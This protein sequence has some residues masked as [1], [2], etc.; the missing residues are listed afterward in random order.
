MIV[1]LTGSMASG[2]TTV[3]KLL[4]ARGFRCVDADEA[5][6]WIIRVPEVRDKL[7]AA[8][9]SDIL[10]VSGSIDRTALAKKAFASKE[11]T[12]LLNSVTHP[13]IIA[14]MLS[15][16]KRLI[17]EAPERPVLMDVPLL[18]ES[19]MDQYCDR[20]VTVAAD[21]EVRYLRIMLRDGIT[22]EEAAKR[23]S[24]Q[25]P[26]SEKCALADAVIDN[27]GGLAQLA[28]N[29]DKALRALGLPP[30]PGCERRQG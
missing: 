8:F 25:M 29:V 14:L 12:A 2:K 6:H 18:F 16:A 10:D 22:R 30:V 9:G 4:T 3:A 26:Q 28:S 11:A 17:T 13:A 23:I 19:G 24:K 15:V 1:G 27:N 20:T 21:D 5:A 7:A